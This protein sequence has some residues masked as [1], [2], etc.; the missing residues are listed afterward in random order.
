MVVS[1]IYLKGYL[2]LTLIF[3]K[4]RPTVYFS[5]RFRTLKTSGSNK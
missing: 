1:L 4:F 3:Q 5:F 2:T